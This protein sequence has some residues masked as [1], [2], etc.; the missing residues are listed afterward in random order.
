MSVSFQRLLRKFEQPFVLPISS[1]NVR[2][3]ERRL[4][5]GSYKGVTDLV[6]KFVWP[7]PAQW[8]VGLCVRCGFRPNLVT[9]ISLLLVILAG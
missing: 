2:I 7:R 4:F 3:L 8:V 1:D 6:T 9:F 5:D